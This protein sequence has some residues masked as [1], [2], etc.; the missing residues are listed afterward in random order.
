MP[1]RDCLKT[2]DVGADARAAASCDSK[3]AS[4]IIDR[5]SRGRNDMVAAD[6]KLQDQAIIKQ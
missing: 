5:E 4:S 6:M 2:V 3:K 1:S